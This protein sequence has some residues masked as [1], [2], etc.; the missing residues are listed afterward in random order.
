[1]TVLASYEILSPMNEAATNKKSGELIKEWR[2]WSDASVLAINSGCKE[3]G[4][5]LQQKAAGVHAAACDAYKKENF[6][7]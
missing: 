5:A 4:H 6:S 2:E 7:I 3:Y 1:M